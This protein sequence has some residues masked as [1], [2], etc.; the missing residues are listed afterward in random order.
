S[1]G[2]GARAGARRPDR[3]RGEPVGAPPD[4]A[5]RGDA[6]RR[7]TGAENRIGDDMTNQA[8]GGGATS[9]GDRRNVERRRGDRR[10]D[11]RRFPV[12]LWR[13][14]WAYAGY[15]VVGALLLVLLIGSLGGEG[16]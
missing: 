5:A 10:R 13:R 8:G 9:R 15:G 16:G 12:P 4:G 1:A 3:Q 6:G 2:P 11:D 14:P 7:R